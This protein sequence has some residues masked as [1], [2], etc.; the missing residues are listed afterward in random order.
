[1]KELVGDSGLE[2]PGDE[3]GPSDLGAAARDLELI[4]D[5]AGAL[6]EAV[7]ED[8]ICRLVGTG[9]QRIIGDD[10]LISVRTHEPA[11]GKPRPPF[12]LGLGASARNVIALIGGEPVDVDLEF[13]PAIKA[14]MRLGRL[15]RVDGGVVELAGHILP[16]ETCEKLVDLL[17]LGDVHV[18]GFVKNEQ[19]L[20]GATI[21][22]RRSGRALRQ[23]AIEALV[24]VAAVAV[25]RRRAVAA[26][27]ESEARYQRL[28]EC[29]PTINTLFDAECRIVVQNSRSVEVLGWPRGEAIGKSALEV[30]GPEG[31][32]VYE[33]MQRVIAQR[34]PEQFVTEY[35][36]PTGNRWLRSWYQPMI[37]AAGTCTGVQVISQEITDIMQAQHAL[38]AS[39]ASLVRI[40]ES[41]SDAIGVSKAGI[42]AF[43]NPAYVAM[44]GYDS[45]KD[46]LG[47]PILELIAPESRAVVQDYIAKR[48][49]GLPAP[50]SYEVHAMRRDGTTFVMDCR[51]VTY[52]FAGELHTLVTLRDVTDTRRAQKVLLE[53]ERLNRM[54]AE[55]ASDYFFHL[56]VSPAGEVVMDYASKGFSEITGRSIG[57][58][59]SVK[60]WASFIHPDD[61]PRLLAELRRAVVDQQPVETEGRSYVRGG[62]LRW[63]L[64]YARP[65][66]DEQ[67]RT[68]G[69]LG[70]VKDTT[71]R[72]RMEEERVKLQEQL[73]QAMKMEAIGRLAGGLAHD[74]NNL[75]TGILGNVD[76]ALLDLE[77]SD[78]LAVTL[79]E[80]NK[81]ALS[82]ATLTHQLLAFSRKQLIEPK[83][84]NLN[85]LIGN[86]QKMLPRLIGE[87]VSLRFVP[88]QDLESVRLDP[89][90]FEQV[91]VNLAVNARDA[92][93]DG[94]ALLIET[95]NVDL[96]EPY[97]ASHPGVAP[98]KY[99]ML[100]VRDNGCG[101][102]K[103]V[104]DRLFEPFFT[105]KPK[106]KG[107][108]LGLATIYGAVKQAEGFIE[109]DSEVGKGTTFRIYLPR[110]TEKA[111]KWSRE[112]A[113]EGLPSGTETILLVEDESIVRDLAQRVLSRL[114]YTVLPAQ[115][116][117]EAFMLAERRKDRIDLLL[118]DVVMPGMNG[119]ELADRLSLLHPE[120]KILYTSGYTE[121]VIVHHGV[122]DQGLRFIGKP[123]TPRSL[124]QKLRKVLD[125]ED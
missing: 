37:D 55:L 82:A 30:F 80:V 98:G 90:Q 3:S 5:V 112:G 57:Q 70:A 99:A 107:T 68:V 122:I 93:P 27:S 61:Y 26:L 67:G 102:T 119:R 114:G 92:M 88:S 72:K 41:S 78:P 124:A 94:G 32:L 109:V 65:E 54:I 33:R 86:L 87:D 1:M 56:A 23:A 105:T 115:N 29:S 62:T 117:G 95:A 36:R 125:D 9:L 31:P 28:F 84:L 113:Y 45:P 104:R 7:A 106:G 10:A 63:I 17:G 6:L 74:F 79:R 39:E 116:G 123:Y 69:I 103:E 22:T 76:L 89:G 66:L 75:L 12:L 21:I 38:R 19:V 97:C 85:D 24:R 64:I 96:D 18:I 101:M 52:Q 34:Q 47:R 35:T 60:D 11:S 91:I 16:P 43:V 100:S 8:E 118:T 40:L 120:M 59:S 15:V 4:A 73:Q 71:E 110:L 44:F 108:G 14:S 48:A 51:V 49:A 53:S 83:V 81:S 111:E 2:A 46:L 42:H 58:V 121:D 50:E 77:A 13:P 20:G 25:E